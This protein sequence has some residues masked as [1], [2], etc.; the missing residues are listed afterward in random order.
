[1][2]NDEQ[3]EVYAD[4]LRVIAAEAVCEFERLRPPAVDWNAVLKTK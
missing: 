4:R 2:D 3:G 1:T